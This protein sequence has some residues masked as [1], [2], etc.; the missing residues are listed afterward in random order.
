[1][2]LS[3]ASCID[4]MENALHAPIR[5]NCGQDVGPN[6]Q[7]FY[8][9]RQQCRARE[10]CRFD[11]LKFQIDGPIL[12]IGRR[13]GPNYSQLRQKLKSLGELRDLVDQIKVVNIRM[14]QSKRGGQ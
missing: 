13:A 1:M 9:A 8:R 5:L 3:Q 7:C 2:L 12:I 11:G 10:D 14:A 6:R 4:L